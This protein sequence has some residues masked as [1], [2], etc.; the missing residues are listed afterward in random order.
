MIESNK[1]GIVRHPLF[2]PLAALAILLLIDLL[3]IPGFFHIEIKDGHLY[4]SLIDIANRAAP[5]ALAAIGMTL[6]LSL[7]HI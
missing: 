2:R 5:L 6:V 4:G 7:I 1:M 3:L